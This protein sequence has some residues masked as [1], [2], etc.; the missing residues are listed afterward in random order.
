VLSRNDIQTG[1][2]VELAAF[3]DLL[4]ATPPGEAA[5]PTRCDGWSVADVGAHVAGG[6]ADVVTFNLDGAGTPEWTQRQVDDRRG[7]SL[8]ELADE[9]EQVTK[10]ATDLMAAFD[11]DAWNGPA[12]AGV[13]STIG[14][15]IEGLFYDVYLHGDDIRAAFGAPSV[16][17]PGLR[18]AVHHVAGLLTDRGW[19]PATLALDGIDEVPVSGGGGRRVTGDPLAFVLAA[20]GRAD[21][22]PLGLGADVNV[23][24]D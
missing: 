1:Y 19:G 22:T 10:V 18:C 24:A 11:D 12:P 13:A 5:T 15:G 6:L 2:P 8:G 4:R 9:L 21:P 17:G 3:A 7:R 14:V 20:T 16:G 23:Y